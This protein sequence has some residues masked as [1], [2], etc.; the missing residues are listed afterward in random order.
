[1][2]LKRMV[3]RLFLI[4]LIVITL[5]LFGSNIYMIRPNE[6][7]YHQSWIILG[8]TDTNYLPVTKLWFERLSDIG[9]E[10]HVIIALDDFSY[11][12]LKVEGKYRCEK[13]TGKL[14]GPG[15]RNVVKLR[16]ATVAKYLEKGKNVFVSDVDTYWNYYFDLNKLSPQYDVFHA[17]ATIW[18][19]T[20]LKKWGFTL[21]TC[22][23][24]YRANTKT[25]EL[26][27]KLIKR[28]GEACS[29]Q[30]VTNEIYAFD[31]DVKWD[32]NSGVSAVYNLT[33]NSF[34]RD[35]VTRSEINCHTWISM[36]KSDQNIE[37]KLKLWKLH[38]EKCENYIS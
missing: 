6:R 24:G 2:V 17:F 10:N 22:I 37:A 26:F 18:P 25:V 38:V 23:A 4:L 31:Y 19:P 30:Q 36:G 5:W 35:F 15:I 21:C 11:K 3:K 28:C 34:T 8:F 1:M 16:L 27:G 9:Y 29:D 20:V 7:N 32:E 13:G 12:S 14:Q 33:L